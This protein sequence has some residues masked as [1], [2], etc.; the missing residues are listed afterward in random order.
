VFPYPHAD[1][2]AADLPRRTQ[3]AKWITSKDN[4]YF[5]KSYVN[6]IWSYLLGVGIIEPVDDIR[7]GNPPTNPELLDRLTKEFIASGFDTR[8]TIKTIC[9][10]R[11]YQLSVSTNQWNKDDEQN[12][13]HALPRRLPAEVLF[14]AIHQATGS[15][16]QLPG[17]PAGSR[18][19]QLVDSNVDLP[20][21]FL[22]L[23]GKPVRES[24]CECERSN[25]M[26]LGPVL[27]M[28]NGPIVGD[29]VKDPAG[30]LSRFTEATKDDAKV[31]E[32]VYLSV[33]N[34][35]PTKEETAAGVTA[36]AGAGSDHARLL[37]AHTQRVTVFEAYQKTLPARQTAWEAARIAEKPTP[38][39]TLPP[40]NPESKK[41]P[42]ATADSG[43]TLTVQ[44]DAAILV[45]GKNGDTDRYLLSLVAKSDAPLTAMRLEVLPDPSLPANGPGRAVNGNFVLTEFVLLAGP[46]T[47]ANASEKTVKFSEATATHE[48]G[49]YP[50]R[51][52]IDGDFATGWAVDPAFGKPNSAIFRFAKPIAAKD[53]VGFTIRMPQAHGTNHSMGKFRLS[54]TSD[55]TPK[56]GSPL[57]PE[58]AKLLD[59]PADMRT[60]GETQRLRD[61]Y[62]AQDP[63][64]HRLQREASNPPPADPRVLGAQ[65]LVWALINSPAFLFN[66]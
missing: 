23:F 22:D 66:H 8:A 37:A 4:P 24:A 6:R 5:A 56:L 28:V 62:V 12:Y 45:S 52:A 2:P 27:A 19:A 54:V 21:G 36:L 20:G 63:E 15:K 18:A 38:W 64:Y 31:V 17:L 48:Q 61:L 9:K 59:G 3:V 26:M 60:A 40:K 53:G 65:D 32:E 10:S 13:S 58:L 25:T 7:A 57:P 16:S 35:R 50:I 42:A 41:G 11:T 49:G 30:H 44:P 47:G 43:A 51:N 1:L 46:A 29:A 55:K 33:L 14:D 34:R 39:E